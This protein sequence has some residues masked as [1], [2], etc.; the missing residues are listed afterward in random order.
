[1]IWKIPLF[2]IY[3][4]E[5]DIKAINDAIKKGIFW[6]I[7]PNI[8]KLERMIVKYIRAKYCAVFNFGILELY[9]ALLAYNIKKRR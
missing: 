7:G 3:W 9:A 1:M 6:A 2:K 4:D 8:E 5:T